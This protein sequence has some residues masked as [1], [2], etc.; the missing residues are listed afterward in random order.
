[1]PCTTRFRSRGELRQAASDAKI[2]VLVKVKDVSCVS[3]LDDEKD[4]NIEW[5]VS[6]G[7]NGFYEEDPVVQK[8][9]SLP[10]PESDYY[11][12]AT[13]EGKFAKGVNDYFVETRGL[14]ANL[15][16]CVAYWH[17]K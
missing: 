16:R 3:Y 15:V 2:T 17:N 11:I 10:L 6:E 4:F 13:G 14:D 7:H 9:K 5:I 12:W 8:L 1:M